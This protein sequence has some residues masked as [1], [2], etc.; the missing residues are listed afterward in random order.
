MATAKKPAPKKPVAKKSIATKASPKKAVSGKA[1]TKKTAVKKAVA[2][3]PVAAKTTKKSGGKKKHIVRRILDFKI[4]GWVSRK[5]VI[6]GGV[7]ALLLVGGFAGYAV[8]QNMSANA[9]G[10]STLGRKAT[11]QQKIQYNKCIENQ[12]AN[13]AKKAAEAKKAAQKAAAAATAAKIAANKAAEAKAA[14]AKAAAAK[15]EQAKADAKKEAALIAASKGWTRLDD[16]I[17]LDNLGA[18]K[19][20]TIYKLEGVVDACK[21]TNGSIKAKL[22]VT[23]SSYPATHIIYADMQDTYGGPSIA[24]GNKITAVVGNVSTTSASTVKY[25]ASANVPEHIY[26]N[27]DGSAIFGED[28]D[29]VKVSSLKYCP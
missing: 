1:V 24:Q 21:L 25:S 26:F 17:K 3:K 29:S 2:K 12:K 7:V 16:E 10:C 11:T 22:T 20:T 9:G 14:A 8:W 28:N 4:K 6:I 15:A 23:K 5:T 18:Q 13:A 27:D 19:G